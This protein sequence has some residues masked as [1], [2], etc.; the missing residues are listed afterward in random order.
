[1]A[2]MINWNTAAFE[3]E[4]LGVT[5][6]LLEVAAWRIVANAKRILASK[7]NGGWKPHGPYS[8]AY[9]KGKY[10][11]IGQSW[12]ARREGAMVATI[13]AVRKK[14]DPSRNIWIMMGNYNVW[15]A[16]QM[17]FGRGAWKGGPKSCIRP[18]MAGAP[19]EIQAV[20]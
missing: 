16:L 4:C 15:W 2:R 5:M 1:M 8:T 6:D 20:L 9:S 19:R 17:E 13:R 11:G 10:H 14:D 7:I 3:K 18:A 12:S